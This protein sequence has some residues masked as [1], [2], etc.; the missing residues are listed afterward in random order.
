MADAIGLKVDDPRF[1]DPADLRGEVDRIFDVCCSCR[2]CFKFCGSFPAIFEFIDQKTERMRSQYLA[3]HPEVVEAADA[4]RRAAAAQPPPAHDP[5]CEIG[6]TYG[7]ELP[8]SAC[9]RRRPQQRAD[10][11]RRRPLLPVQALLSELPL[12]AA[13]RIRDRLPAPVAALESAAHAPP[14]RADARAADARHGD[15]RQARQPGARADQ[16]GAAQLGQPRGDGGHSR[17]PP[18]EADA[19]AITARRCRGG[20]SSDRRRS[21]R[22]CPRRRGSSNRSRSRWRSSRP[23]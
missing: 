2:L 20:G 8:E 15:D 13:A 7:D 6:V 21:K 5:E 1:W 9:E 3:A 10:R 19:D 17:H 16:L 14:G 23:A 11:P 12:H 22:R 4:K 18:R